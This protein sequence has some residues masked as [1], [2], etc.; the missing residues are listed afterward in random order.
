MPSVS[1]SNDRRDLSPTSWVLGKEGA[2]TRHGSTADEVRS[3][4]VLGQCILDFL[5]ILVTYGVSDRAD[6]E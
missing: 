2:F 6:H 1:F 4:I 5:G 3:W